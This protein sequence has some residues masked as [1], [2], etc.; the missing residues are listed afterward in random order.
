M[1]TRGRKADKGFTLVEVMIAAGIL[2]TGFAAVYIASSQ[3]M[4]ISKESRDLSLASQV[5][6]E[7]MENLRS[8]LFSGSNSSIDAG[9]FQTLIASPTYS[10][11]S[12]FRLPGT[13]TFTITNALA[14]SGTLTASGNV[15]TGG[16]IASGSTV[17]PPAQVQLTLNW[18]EGFGNYQRNLS[19]TYV[20]VVGKD[21]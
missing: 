2:V 3:C 9:R 4:R 18:S 13:E 1:N 11:T 10:G 8:T 21:N 16:G 6:Q 19:R 17:S 14:S 20:T 12:C 5:L 15:L 7:R